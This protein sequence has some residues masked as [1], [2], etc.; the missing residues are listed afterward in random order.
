MQT[1]LDIKLPAPE[2]TAA[3]VGQLAGFLIGKGWLTAKQINEATGLDDRRVRAIAEHSA[4]RIL[5]GPGCPGYRYFDKAAL[6]HAEHAIAGFESQA[7]KMLRRA[8]VYR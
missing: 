2:V 7:T 4:G 5:S 1:E 6:P 8:N 3:E